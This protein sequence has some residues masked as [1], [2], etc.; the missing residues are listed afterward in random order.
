MKLGLTQR[1]NCNY[2]PEQ[3]EQLLVCM[4]PTEEL[5]TL[6]KQLLHAGFRRSGEQLYRP[7]CPSCSK[8]QSVRVIAE[9]FCTSKS[10]RRILSKN[11]DL[12]VKVSDQERD[13]HYLLYALYIES[14]H[15]DG[16]MYPPS[17]VQYRNFIRCQWQHPLFIEARDQSGVLLAVAVTDQIDDGLS[18]L[19]T[20]YAPNAAK[21]SLGKFMIMQQIHHAKLL[22]LP[23]VYLGYQIDECYKMNYKTAFRPFQRLID[24]HWQL[25]T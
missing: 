4:S 22:S 24:N 23:Y 3:E 25:F 13:D 11:A 19:Y 9:Q 10:Q 1:F 21:R 14:M 17:Y 12:N 7:H 8:C 2:L 16:S 15:A 20:Y 18:A 5:P 6:Y